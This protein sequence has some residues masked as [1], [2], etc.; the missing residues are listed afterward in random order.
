MAS[1]PSP[2]A[3][4]LP[5][6]LLSQGYA[7]R[8][9]TDGDIPFLMDLYASTRAQELAPVPWTQDQK[10][11]FL[12]S[13]FQAQRHHYR[14]AIAGCLFDVL[15]HHGVPAGRLYLDV[16]P[17][18][19]HIIDIALMPA[20]RGRGLG[21]AILKALQADARDRGVAVGIM[22]EK[23]NPAMR[24][25]RR[26]GFADIADREVYLE[27]EWRPTGGQLNVA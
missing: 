5:A 18:R 11:G 19:L 26:L 27:M 21:T 17:T 20:W 25:Y 15:E 22:V 14:N 12:A 6:A 13:Q 7:L 24:L 16:R 10:Q 3:F 23:F 9:E 4:V 2:P 1:S 8:P